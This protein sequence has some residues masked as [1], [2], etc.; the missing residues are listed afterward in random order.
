MA[1]QQEEKKTGLWANVTSIF[2][3]KGKQEETQKEP[4]VQ[5]MAPST[6]PPPND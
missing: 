5:Q 2:S 4:E 3:K 6:P 1:K